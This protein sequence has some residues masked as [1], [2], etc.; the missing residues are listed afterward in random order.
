MTLHVHNWPISTHPLV[1]TA[2]DL[3][4]VE[5][6]KTAYWRDR[7]PDQPRLVDVCT[8]KDAIIGSIER[9]TMMRTS[10]LSESC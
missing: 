8:E 6:A 7:W 9:V 2:I 10:R 4:R 5:T 3:G 1:A